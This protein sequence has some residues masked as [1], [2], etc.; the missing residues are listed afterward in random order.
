MPKIAIFPGTFDPMTKGHVDLIARASQLFD[1]VIV[2]IAENKNKKPLFSLEERVDQVNKSIKGI[3]HVFAEGFH[4][5]LADF[6]KQKKATAIVRGVRVV[7]DFE[8]EFQL[9]NMNRRLVPQA[10]T[11]FLTPSEEYAFVS[12]TLVK[13]IAMHG[14]DVSTFVPA[15]VVKALMNRF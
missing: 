4:C 13:E 3:S 12:S 7:S 14:G 11:V 2:A 5:L 10:E 1:H 9:A 6:V 8:Y 15:C